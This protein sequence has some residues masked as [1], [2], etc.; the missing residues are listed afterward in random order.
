MAPRLM[1]PHGAQRADYRMW[2]MPR[3]NFTCMVIDPPLGAPRGGRRNYPF[4]KFL[5]KSI[6]YE[7]VILVD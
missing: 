2:Y 3:N 1:A 6:H 4:I 7:K 5:K